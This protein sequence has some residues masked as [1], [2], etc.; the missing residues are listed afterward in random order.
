MRPLN[1]D[2]LAS[3]VAI[4]DL[5]GF[6]AAAR[7]RNLSQPA[8]SQ[9]IRDLEERHGVALV[10]RLGRRVQPTLAGRELI[11]HARRLLAEGEAALA[12]LKRHRDGGLGRVRIGTGTAALTYLLPPILTRLRREQ[13]GIELAVSTGPTEEMLERLRAGTLDLGLVTLPADTEGFQVRRLRTDP[14]VALLPAGDAALAAAVGPRPTAPALA[15]QTLILEGNRGSHARLI[16]EWFAAAGLEM[17]AAM[18]LSSIEAV[19][20]TVIA[21]LGCAIL[22][23]EVVAGENGKGLTVLELDPPVNRTL[24]LVHRREKL[25][26]PAFRQVRRALLA[27]ARP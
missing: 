24:A 22:P 5:G 1:L 8:I 12:T 11:A 4:A 2:Q 27:L 18:W 17:R 15:K 16:R 21:G 13:P 19:R 10:E 3:L 25:E 14:I 26:D 9:Q 20:H 6:T 23:S 7:A